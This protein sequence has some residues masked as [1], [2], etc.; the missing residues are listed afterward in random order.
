MRYTSIRYQSTESNKAVISTRQGGEV[1]DPKHADMASAH[2]EPLNHRPALR[3]N[4]DA[5]GDIFYDSI[6]GTNLR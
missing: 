5:E 4:E 2:H 3:I 1:V 6:A